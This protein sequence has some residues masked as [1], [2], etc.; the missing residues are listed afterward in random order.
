METTR[1]L[2]SI[3]CIRCSEDSLIPIVLIIKYYLG[4]LFQSNILGAVTVMIV[5]AWFHWLGGVGWR[6]ND[7]DAGRV[8]VGG[9]ARTAQRGV[10]PS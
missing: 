2:F 6:G 10:P 1:E 8:V 4:S 3:G 9:L 7:K 5:V